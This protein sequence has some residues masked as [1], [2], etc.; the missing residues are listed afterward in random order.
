[1]S[2][3]ADKPSNAF[4][5]G[6]PTANPQGRP[7]GTVN[8]KTSMKVADRLLGKW[9]IHPADKL[10]EIAKHLSDMNQHEEAAEIWMT[11][12]KYFEP[13]KKPVEMA[14]EKTTPQEAKEAAEETFKLLQQ[15]ENYG[16]FKDTASSKDN[17]MGT[18]SPQVSPQAGTEK[19]L[20]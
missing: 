5:P 15:I 12:L 19:D 17:G 18:T 8:K 2:L 13:S 9:K 14:P 11:L 20:R 3:E 10:V 1:M 4:K 16:T 7:K 6:Q